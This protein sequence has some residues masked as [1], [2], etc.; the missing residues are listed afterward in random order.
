[1][2]DICTVREAEWLGT[3]DHHPIIP[4]EPTSHCRH[5]AD[6]PDESHPIAGLGAMHDV[7]ICQYAGQL[8][9]ISVGLGHPLLLVSQIPALY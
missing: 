3:S 6:R 5:Q 9:C 4:K 2:G 7:F 8:Y 1:M